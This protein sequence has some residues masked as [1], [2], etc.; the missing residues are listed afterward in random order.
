MQIMNKM[1]PLDFLRMKPDFKG[2]ST[3][4]HGTIATNYQTAEVCTLTYVLL[5][6]AKGSKV[7]K[8]DK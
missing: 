6:E 4:I 1:Q 3:A 8:N 2:L 5:L 7:K